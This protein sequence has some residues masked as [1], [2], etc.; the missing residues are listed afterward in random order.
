ME[1]KIGQ[2][3]WRK[4]LATGL[5]V[6]TLAGV[7]LAVL[8]APKSGKDTRKQLGGALLKVRDRVTRHHGVRA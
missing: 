3:S 7:T 6:G 2:R 4:P 8:F 5:I 1:R